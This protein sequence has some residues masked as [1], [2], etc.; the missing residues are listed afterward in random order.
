MKTL[1]VLIGLPRSGKSTKAKELGFPIVETDAIRRTLYK[2]PFDPANELLVQGLAKTMIRTLFECHDDVTL[3]EVNHT[4]ARR[5]QWLSEHW[6]THFILIKTS[7]E[8]CIARALAG[9]RDYLIPIID[10]MAANFE[11]LEGKDC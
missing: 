4:S 3:D 6:A 10:R 5:S 9:G 11:P 7:K 2:E 1:H 8:E